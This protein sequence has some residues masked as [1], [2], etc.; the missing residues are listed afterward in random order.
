MNSKT[1]L[2][3]RLAFCIE[4]SGIS[5]Q[6]LVSGSAR[7]KKGVGKPVKPQKSAKVKKLLKEKTVAKIARAKRQ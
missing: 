6:M 7:P 5:L 4:P 1:A 3:S 2:A